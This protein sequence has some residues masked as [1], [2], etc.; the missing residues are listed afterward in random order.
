MPCSALLHGINLAISKTIVNTEAINLTL[1][2]I[3]L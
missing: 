1:L 3:T 2:N